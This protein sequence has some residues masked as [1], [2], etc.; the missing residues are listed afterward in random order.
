MTGLR[1]AAALCL[2]WLAPGALCAFPGQATAPSKKAPAQKKSA[3]AALRALLAEA[4]SAEQKKDYAAA[5]QAYSD[6]LAQKPDDAA[7]HFQLGYA[8]SAL[9]QPENAASE[10]RKAIELDP[11]LGEAY[12]NLGLTLLE[13]NP[14]EAIEPLRRAVE[15]LPSRPR[16][17]YLLGWA[18]ERTGQLAPAIEQYE[19][20]EKLDAK[21]F[22]THFALGRAYLS[23]NRAAPAEA[24]FRAALELQQDSSPAR[25]GLGQSLIA[26][27]KTEAAAAELA[28]YLNAQPQDAQ[29]RVQRASLLFDLG[30][31]DEALGE[32]DRAAAAEPESVAALKL[33]SEIYLQQSKWNDAAQALAKVLAAAPRDAEAHAWLG[34][35]RLQ[36]KDYP[37]A[38]GELTQALRID[39]RLTEALRDLVAAEYLG[40]NYPAALQALDLLAQ[41]ETPHAG[42]WFIRATCYDK[43]GRKPEALAAYQKFL[44]LNAGQT[45]D[46]YFEASARARLLARELKE[47]KK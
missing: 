35:A 24:E 2:F 23:A 25:L 14:A 37:G 30:R 36:Q 29:T 45:N 11:K 40:G 17:K 9:A 13:K 41:R 12:Q 16:P 20:A 34:H 32:L 15:L 19:A 6:Y 46:Q 18:L 27:K 8:Y 10:Y 7:I 26:Q 42:S 31:N 43:L 3:N 39:S 33:R 22:D 28:P 38:T 4:Q 47:N 1:N 5:A 44:E 21:S